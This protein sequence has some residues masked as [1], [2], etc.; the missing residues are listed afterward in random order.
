MFSTLKK[1][2]PYTILLLTI[3]SMVLPIFYNYSFYIGSTA[4]WWL[5]SLLMLFWW[6]S[7]INFLTTKKQRSL[8]KPLTIYIMWNL[9]AIVR[10]VFVADDYWTWKGLIGNAFAL[11]LPGVAFIITNPHISQLLL[12]TYIK[13]ALPIILVF[14][15]FMKPVYYEYV[16]I[17]MVVMFAFWPFLKRKYKFLF[18]CAI[19]LLLFSDLTAR[20]TIIKAT[21]SILIVIFF[22]LC[23][24]L[25][26]FTFSILHK[27]IMILPIIFLFTAYLGFFNPFELDSYIDIEIT[28]EKKKMD[29]TIVEEDLRGDSRSDLY[30]EVINSA[31]NNSYILI[32]RTPARG[33][34]TEKFQNIS[35]ITG[36]RERGSNEAAILNVFTWT[37]IIG[38]ILY[39]I[40]FFHASHLAVNRSNNIISKLLGL[41]LAFRWLYSWVSDENQ[42]H[43]VYFSIFLLVGLCYSSQFRAMTNE[44]FFYW[45]RGIFSKSYKNYWIAEYAKSI[46]Y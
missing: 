30:I 9:I 32:G 20:G 6:Y 19:L 8:M 24:Y 14:V 21:F 15:V 16:L 2:I 13:Y 11:L 37:G 3:K 12:K 33:N 29:G 18:F 1:Y 44:E 25:P 5:I 36:K 38:V 39:F 43:L 7:G 17:I 27:I 35:K 4:M 31:I 40:L 26:R 45:I 23:K 10:G 28:V 46:K 41:M 34:D 42:F 22:Y